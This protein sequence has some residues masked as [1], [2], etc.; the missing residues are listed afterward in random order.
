MTNTHIHRLL[1]ADRGS[2]SSDYGKGYCHYEPGLIGCLRKYLVF[3]YLDGKYH[4]CDLPG[5]KGIRS[6]NAN[7]LLKMAVDFSGYRLKN[8]F[9]FGGK[10]LSFCHSAKRNESISQ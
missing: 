9:Y 8:R 10:I 2:G 4:A 5:T 6:C 1:R 3:Y 7:K